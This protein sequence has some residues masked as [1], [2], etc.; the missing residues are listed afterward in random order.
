MALATAKLFVAEV[1]YVFITG[2]RQSELDKALKEIGHN[3][4]TVQADYGK[5]EDLDKLFKIVK[6]ENGSID[7]LYASAGICDF[8]VP[9]HDVTEDVYFSRIPIEIAY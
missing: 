2:R 7:I 3:V 5:M 9:I 1:A 8:N 4:T 6:K